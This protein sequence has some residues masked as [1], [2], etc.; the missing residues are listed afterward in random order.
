MSIFGLKELLDLLNL[1]KQEIH[2]ST[3]VLMLLNF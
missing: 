2:R 3:L 1:I